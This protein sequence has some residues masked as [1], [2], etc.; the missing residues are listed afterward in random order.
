MPSVM[1]AGSNWTGSP[2][3]P[4]T[5]VWAAA[6]PAPARTRAA[7]AA[8]TALFSLMELPPWWGVDSLGRTDR[9]SAV[10]PAGPGPPVQLAAE[11]RGLGGGSLTSIGLADVGGGPGPEGALASQEWQGLQVR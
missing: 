3:D 7:A 8:R 11:V 2:W 6:G 5:N 10:R 1:T 4:N 9:G